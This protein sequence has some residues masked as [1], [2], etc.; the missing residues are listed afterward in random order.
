MKERRGG[1]TVIELIV[2]ISVIF[3]LAGIILP[4][5]LMMKEKAKISL[6]K[7]QLHEIAEAVESYRMR[8]GRYPANHTEL[9]KKDPY[10]VPIYFQKVPLND[11]W[12]NPYFY[13]AWEEEA[14]FTSPSLHRH[15]PPKWEDFQFYAQPG[16]YTI[17]LYLSKVSSA[18]LILNGEEIFHPSEFNPHVKTLSKQINLE[19]YNN[20]SVRITS[21][22]EATM[23]I[24]I[25]K[26]LPNLQL[27]PGVLPPIEYAGKGYNWSR[28]YGHPYSPGFLLGSYGVDGKP[29][30]EGWDEDI[31]YGRVE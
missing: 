20:L 18:R 12:G 3:V 21:D 6:A 9:S 17:Y 25:V 30:G 27:E 11:P 26:T 5:G 23:K 2:V 8:E 1:L 10:G 31:I 22:P 29:G 4:Q 16:E 24:E 28:L 7:L 19:S 14:V 15:T 13:D